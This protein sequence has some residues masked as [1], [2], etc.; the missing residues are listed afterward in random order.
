MNKNNST[1]DYICCAIVFIAYKKVIEFFV[2][3][4]DIMLVIVY[5]R[6]YRNMRGD[7]Y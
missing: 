7:I 3:F 4:S 6:I 2:V 1:T 5:Y